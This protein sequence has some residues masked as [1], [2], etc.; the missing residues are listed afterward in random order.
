MTPLSNTSVPSVPGLAGPERASGAPALNRRRFLAGTAAGTALVVGFHLPSRHAAAQGAAGKGFAPN[1]YLRIGADDSVTIVVALVEMGQGTFTSIP[2]LIAEELDVDMARVRVEQAPADEKRFGHPL[3]GLQTTGGSASVK[4]AWA[5]LRQVGAVAKS[6]LVGA[7]AQTWNVPAAECTAERGVVHHAASRRS[8]RYGELVALASTL[9]VPAE[10]P[11]KDPARFRIVGT[12]V[13]R[14]DLPAKVDGSA[15]FGIDAKVPGM[16]I[17][18]IALCPFIGGRLLAVDDA[19]AL[20]VHGVLRVLRAPAAVAVV[21]EHYGAAK[22]GL[23]ALQIRWEPGSAARFSNEVW[24]EQLTAALRQKGATYHDDGDFDAAFRAAA[25]RHRAVYVSPPLAHAALEPLHCTLHVRRD[26]CDV[27]LGTQAPARVQRYVAQATG[28]PAERVAVHNFLLGG[29]FGRRL[30]AD[31]VIPAAELAR[32][33]DHPLKIVWSREQDLQHDAY[34]PCFVDELS[35]GLDAR[36]NLVAFRNRFAGSAVITRYAPEWLGQGG[37][38]PDVAH[39]AESAY[40]VANRRVE[41]VRHEP[42]AGLLTGNWRGVGPTHHAFVTECFL[43]E[44]AQLAGVDPVAYRERLLARQPRLLAMLRLAA[45]KSGWG[46][47]LGPRRGRGIAVVE[48]WDCHAALV[49]EVTLARDGAVTIDRMVC[50][51]DC[52][53]AVHPDGVDAQIQGGIA[54]GLTAALYGEVRFEGGRVVQSNYHDYP[55]LRLHEMPP[56]ELHLA[57]SKE[58]P[59]GVGELGTALAP[60]SFMNAL[61]AA[62]RKRFRTYPV[63]AAELR[64]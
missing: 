2:M 27:W 28:L 33:V 11:L 62:A 45:A 55:P 42:P 31:Y 15:Q 48:S 21:A 13:P 30:D 58:P 34:R 56:I 32:Q 17:A 49:T 3:Y 22:K 60:A 36:G 12:S 51:V 61:S 43:D 7:A 35:A 8:L 40:P 57:P 63:P 26:G 1:A 59:G 53:L 10:A 46:R 50:A 4:A 29:G 38:D 44:L 20:K 14:L 19:P 52:G 37:R 47:P 39:G 16:K 24:R 5:K 64:A 54:Y 41:F 6:M 25:R 23:D 18:A 9:P